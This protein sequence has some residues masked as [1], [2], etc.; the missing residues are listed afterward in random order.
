MA[1]VFPLGREELCPYR[2]RFNPYVAF[3]L[4]TLCPYRARFNRYLPTFLP[5]LCPYRERYRN[6][7]FLSL[8]T[9]CPYRTRSHHSLVANDGARYRYTS[10]LFYRCLASAGQEA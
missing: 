3:S 6:T 5:T 4:P 8:P 2:A 10:F 7:T 9:L 1:C